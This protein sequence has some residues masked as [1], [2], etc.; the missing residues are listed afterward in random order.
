MTNAIVL[1]DES[2]GGGGGSGAGHMT[3]V[4]GDGDSSIPNGTTG[5]SAPIPFG[6]SITGWTIAEVS[7][8]PVACSI[9]VEIWKT[10]LAGY[11]PDPGD[12]I[13]G[14]E[15]PELVADT[16]QVN[17]SLSTWTSAYVAEDCFGFKVVSTDNLAKKIA[18]VLKM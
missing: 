10:T 8:P 3:I 12:V 15:P 5:F 4:I 2:G 18:I 6:G 16:V 17:N 13:S 7:N 9:E 1:P 14:T 11:P